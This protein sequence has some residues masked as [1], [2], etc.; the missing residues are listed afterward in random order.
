MIPT[1][2]VHI[3]DL[4]RQIVSNVGIVARTVNQLMLGKWPVLITIRFSKNKA[5]IRLNGINAKN[6]WSHVG[7]L[8]NRTNTNGE[9]R[10]NQV[11][12]PAM[13]RTII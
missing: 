11:T 12:K 4:V 8:P 2:T 7:N 5:V 6:D 13:T 1:K 3:I 9:I 10:G